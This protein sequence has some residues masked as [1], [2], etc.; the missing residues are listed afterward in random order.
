[1]SIEIKYDQNRKILSISISGKSNF[2][3]YTSAL[4]TITSSSDYPPNIRTL[5]DL[6]KADLSSANLNSIKEIVWIRSRFKQR[7][8]CKVALLAPTNLQYGISRMFQMLIENK[9]PH[10]L[11]I[12]R[13]YDEGEQWLLGV[14]QQ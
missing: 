9:L 7:D 14:R 12:F 13:D 1:M 3:E 10:E 4:E 11:A 6:R 5:W 2:D 8:Y